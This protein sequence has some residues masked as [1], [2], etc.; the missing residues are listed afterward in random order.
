ME[1]TPYVPLHQAIAE[2]VWSIE[3]IVALF[4]A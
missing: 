2:H 1:T 4:D 3:E